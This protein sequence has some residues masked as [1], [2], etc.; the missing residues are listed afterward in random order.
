MSGTMNKLNPSDSRDDETQLME[1]C[2]DRENMLKAWKRVKKNGGSPGVD[3][4]TI[5]ESETY[6]QTNW[7]RIRNELL[8]GSY[9]P[10]PVRK[11]EIE[12]SGGG[13]RQLGIPTVTDRLIQQCILQILQPIWDPTFHPNSYGFRPGKSAHQ[14]V[15]QAQKYVQEGR[16]FVVD[17]DLEKFFDRVN[18]DILMDRV[19]KRVKDER[20]V[21]LIRRYLQAGIMNHGVVI[22]RDEGTPQGGPLSPLLSNLLL[23]EVDWELEKR[24]LAF[25]RYA[26]DCN[27]YVKSQRAAD[28]AMKTM[29]KI[30]GKLKLKINRI[31]SKAG[32]VLKRKFLG[33]S[34]WISTTREVKRK[35]ADQALEKCKE[36]VRYLTSRTCGR[37]MKQ[38]IEKLNRYLVGWKNY[39][40][41]ADTPKIFSRL[42]SWIRR[43]LR[44]LL[45]KQWKRG[46]TC[47]R[48]LV[49][50]GLSSK[51]AAS[52][53]SVH[54]SYW[55]MAGS[56][57]MEITFPNS[58][59]DA[60]E[61]TRLG[62]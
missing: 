47:Y 52:I 58:Y 53:A 16:R 40:Q 24:G 48:E 22:E 31:K 14:A 34:L 29:E 43:R 3:E 19:M 23:D 13:M 30:M 12:K 41:L 18:H 7:L 44:M 51:A 15:M 36:K 59:F 20:L 56:S 33:Y 27:V 2:V 37:S 46:T 60:L 4:M 21:K 50:R 62:A 10:K 55:R 39:F 5:A 45:L 11:V 54:R 38:V 42:D 61:L 25:A 6:L 32:T 26:D 1:R 9:R 8:E 49:A 28:R 57:G 17:V 35:V